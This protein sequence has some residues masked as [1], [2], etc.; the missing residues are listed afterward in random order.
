VTHPLGNRRRPAMIVLG[1]LTVALAVVL[2]STNNGWTQEGASTPGAGSSS[3]GSAS[4]DAAD[5]DRS[6]TSQSQSQ[7]G[8]TESQEQPNA[9]SESSTPG[10]VDA[11]DSAAARTDDADE[12]RRRRGLF[13]GRRGDGETP[14]ERTAQRVAQAWMGVRL[15]TGDAQQQDG[16]EAQ[17]GQQAQQGVTVVRVF[18][19]G[20]AARAG[21]YSGDTIVEIDGKSITSPEDLAQVI[22]EKKPNDRLEVV[23][24]SGTERETVR[25]SL[26]DRASFFPYQNRMFGN[27][28]EDYDD[29]EMYAGTRDDDDDL[30][31]YGVAM[32][33]EQERHA[34]TQRKRIEDRL[35]QLT[36]EVRA[37]RQEVQQLRAG[38]SGGA[39]A[40][41]ARTGTATERRIDINRNTDN[42]RNK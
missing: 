34:V 6:A 41:P 11:Q 29:D 1:E 21:I 27:R 10:R 7:R 25:V 32:Q 17:S 42:T 30:E 22:R 31:S 26:A 18:P 20:P 15:A 4:G 14:R 28:D 35:M 13:S 40:T 9:Q 5:K 38:A 8:A 24:L 2:C 12:D 3:A 16:Q 33:L 23:I 36:E 39:A 19:G 37:L